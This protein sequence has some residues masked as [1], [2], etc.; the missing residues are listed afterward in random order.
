M[1]I[2]QTGVALCINSKLHIATAGDEYNSAVI[3]TKQNYFSFFSL[4]DR[5]WD[6]AFSSSFI[7]FSSG[8][9]GTPT[10]WPRTIQSE[11]EVALTFERVIKDAFEAQN[12]RTLC[13]IAFPLGADP[14]LPF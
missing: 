3:L 5:C 1:Y 4:K 2:R 6:G 7:H 13:V 12:Q 10:L 9:T 11:L 14:R 8:S